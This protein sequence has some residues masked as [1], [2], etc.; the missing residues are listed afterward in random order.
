M[1][2]CPCGGRLGTQQSS[3]KLLSLGFDSGCVT[4]ASELPFLTLFLP[5]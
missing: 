5:W 2:L 1:S 4:G 3:F